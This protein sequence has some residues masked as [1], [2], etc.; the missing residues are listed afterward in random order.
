MSKRA[1]QWF[2]TRLVFRTWYF[3]IVKWLI[4]LPIA[5]VRKAQV[6]KKGAIYL[7]DRHEENE[8]K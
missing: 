8:A 6:K 4:F 5:A 1:L 7:Y 2:T 3:A